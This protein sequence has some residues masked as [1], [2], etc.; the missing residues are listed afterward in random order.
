[1]TGIH[2]VTSADSGIMDSNVYKSRTF[3][4]V[5]YDRLV[6]KLREIEDANRGMVHKKTDGLS[7]IYRSELCTSFR[8]KFRQE[9]KCCRNYRIVCRDSCYCHVLQH[10]VSQ[11][12]L[13]ALWGPLEDVSLCRLHRSLHR[14]PH[15]QP[16]QYEFN[17]QYRICTGTALQ[18]SRPT[19]TTTARPVSSVLDVCEG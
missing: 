11:I 6:E 15:F 12:C 16:T 4:N 17:Q 1:M 18:S 7:T 10:A 19:P 5:G 14:D 8:C 13:T 3:K 2:T 9:S